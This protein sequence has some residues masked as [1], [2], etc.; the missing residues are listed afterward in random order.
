MQLVAAVAVTALVA[1]FAVTAA[2]G[3]VSDS[4]T[5]GATFYA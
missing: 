4:Q 3:L 2:V 5:A 1:P